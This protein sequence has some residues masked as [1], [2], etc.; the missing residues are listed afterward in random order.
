VSPAGAEC[1]AE[2]G[3]STGT[4]EGGARGEGS[5]RE[6]GE[7]P[8]GGVEAL[9][10]RRAV[11]G[12]PGTGCDRGELGDGLK[13]AGVVVIRKAEC[14][15]ELAVVADDEVAD[16]GGVEVFGDEA[17]GARGVAGNGHGKYGRQNMFRPLDRDRDEN[18]RRRPPEKGRDQTDW[19]GSAD[20]GTEEELAA[21]DAAV[22]GTGDDGGARR[23]SDDGGGARVVAVA[24]GE[25]DALE[26]QVDGLEGGEDGGR[27]IG[28]AGVDQGSAPGGE[29]DE[30]DVGAAGSVEPPDA[31]D[32]EFGRA[33]VHRCGW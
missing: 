28:E 18:G 9:E 21:V 8:Q 5:A 4:F 23:G 30:K 13:I 12:E 7:V 11:A 16:E 22:A 32:D 29:G 10:Q 31:G 2:A 19:V 14:A 26:R 3:Q 24:V 20:L 33:L 17:E 15:G 6:G 27:A 1:G 25:E